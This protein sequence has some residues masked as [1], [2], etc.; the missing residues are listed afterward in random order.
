M[1][2]KFINPIVF[3]IS[4]AIAIVIVYILQPEPIKV[5]KFPNPE[6]TGK[7]TYQDDNENCYKYEATEVKCPSDPDLI[8]EHPLII[9]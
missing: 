9:K 2:D 4:F 7:Y 8:L 1:L 6:N 5:Y 3:I